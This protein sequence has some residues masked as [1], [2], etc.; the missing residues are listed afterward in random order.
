MKLFV[1]LAIVAST[2]AFA[3]RWNG[4]NHP[5][6]FSRVAGAPMITDFNNLPLQGQVADT[7]YVWSDTYWPSNLG[8]ISYRWNHPNPQPFT[9]TF[10]SKA[11]IMSMS[12]EQL[13]QLSPSELYDIAQG[14]YNY[15]LTRKARSLYHRGDLWWEGICHGWALAATIYPEPAPVTVT[16][17]DGVRVP[18]GTSDVKALLSMHE[19]YNYN[20]RKYGFVGQRCSASGKVPG[21]GDDRD[22][23]PNEPAPSERNTEKCKDVNAGAFHVVISNML[24]IHSRSFVADID[25]YNDVWNQPIFGFSSSMIGEEAVSPEERATGIER[26]V[27]ISTKFTYGEELQIW[28][29]EKAAK[30]PTWRHWVSKVPVTGTDIQQFRHKQYEYIIE[31][32][33]NG[34]I[35]GGEWIT[36]TRPDFM[37][38]YE[39]E[40]KFNNKVIRLDGL[41]TIYRPVRR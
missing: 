19:A 38:I 7:R 5:N 8:G 41:N 35:I 11:E 25:R 24:G 39:R 32:S 17:R 9:Y 4:P 12:T 40:A 14:D 6:N 10:H 15:S 28:T 22:R 36:E 16:N 26:K 27:R 33:A 23:N 18:F 34:S 2:T 30:N 1:A 13:S 21:E 3:E 20:G 29:A 31:I 37:W